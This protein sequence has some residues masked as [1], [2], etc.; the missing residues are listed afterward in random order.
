M[1]PPIESVTHNDDYLTIDWRD[2][3]QSKH[4]LIW[5]RDNDPAGFH[6]DTGERNHDLLSIPER[7]ML[8]S[9]SADENGLR[10]S[11]TDG[12]ESRF[13]AGWLAEQSTLVGRRA[14]A[15]VRPE[16]WDGTFADRLPRHDY[17]PLMKDD[18]ALLAWLEDLTRWGLTIVETAPVELS[19]DGGALEA[20]CRRVAH[21]RET[22]F[23]VVFDVRSIPKPNNQAYTADALPLHTDLPNQETPPGYQ[24]LHTLVNDAEGGL[25][26]FADGMRMAEDL[27]RDD[28]EAYRLLRDVSIPYRFH[29]TAFDIRWRRPVVREDVHGAPVE[30]N[31]NPAIADIP[32]LGP[33]ETVAYYRAYRAFMALTRDQRYVVRL[34]TRPGDLVAFDNRR[35]LHGRTAF[36]PSTGRRHLRGCYVDNSDL[37]SRIRVLRR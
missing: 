31:F 8:M 28:Q 25:S 34:K 3:R 29:D 17:A 23:G 20:L 9:T 30:I 10:L 22:N 16:S 1:M 5:L 35:A 13:E 6:P 7:P 33:E 21:L 4:A 36:D 24:F 11:W 15:P 2:G 18:W 32:D 12:Q 27:H 37:A 19:E 26:T 14:E